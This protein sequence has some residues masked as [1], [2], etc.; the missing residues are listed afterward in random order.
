MKLAMSILVRDEAEL[1]RANIR[2][3]AQLGV[4]CFVVTDNGSVDSTAEVLRDLSTEYELI[5][6]DEPRYVMQQDVWVERMASVARDRLGAD[7]ILNSDADEFWLPAEGV[8]LGSVFETSAGVLLFPRRNVLPTQRDVAMPDYAFHRNTWKVIRPFENAADY[9]SRPWGL[10]E[11]PMTFTRIGDKAACRLEGL[12]SIQYGNHGAEHD[13]PKM[14][15]TAVEIRHFPLRSYDEFLTKVYNH[16]KSLESNPALPDSIGWHVRRWWGL[17][18]AGLL[19][20]EYANLVPT[21]DQMETYA[22]QGVVARD[23]AIAR[24]FEKQA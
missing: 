4:D 18:R 6:I 10:T 22:E 24:R 12:R 14:R 20:S 1:V 21:H 2:F 16:G 15:S 3:H 7:W 8:S 13:A 11:I 17:H 23:L 9:Q 5:V 19:E